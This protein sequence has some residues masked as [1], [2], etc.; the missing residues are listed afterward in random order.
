M[1]RVDRVR[2]LGAEQKK[3][4]LWGR[5]CIMCKEKFVFPAATLRDAMLCAVTL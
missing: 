3:R 5:D 1:A 4:G 2:V